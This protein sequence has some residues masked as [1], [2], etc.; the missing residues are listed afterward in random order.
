VCPDRSFSSDHAAR[1]KISFES[2]RCCDVREHVAKRS[3]FREKR[4]RSCGQCKVEGFREMERLQR[5]CPDLP[6]DSRR[7]VLCKEARRVPYDD[8]SSC[9]LVC[10]ANEPTP[11]VRLFCFDRIRW[12]LHRSN[13]SQRNEKEQSN[14]YCNECFV[15]NQGGRVDV[16]HFSS[17]FYGSA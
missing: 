15:H 11:S 13:R 12:T 6:H 4:A 5:F 17:S 16:F 2:R 8:V 10:A 7:F 1:F 14:N 3:T 9:F